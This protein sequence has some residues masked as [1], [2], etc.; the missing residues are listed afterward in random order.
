MS[1]QR[2]PFQLRGH[3]ISRIDAFSDVVFG[4]ALTLLV[5]SLEVPHTFGELMDSLHGFLPFS[6]CFFLL[7]QIWYMHYKFFRRYG[8]EDFITICL[9]SGLLFVVLLF[10]YPLKFLFTLITGHAGNGAMGAN[11]GR[12]L[13][14]IYGFGFAA[15]WLIFGLM[16]L[17]VRSHRA[18]LK[19][20]AVEL[21]DTDESI[22][23]CF[24]QMALGLLSVVVAQLL[25]APRAGLSGFVY[26]LIGAAYSYAGAHYGRMRRITEDRML[27][28]AEPAPAPA[29]AATV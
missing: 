13:M 2:I 15:V 24:A 27:A 26:M 29:A 10:V 8:L 20:N 18:E 17:N 12:T 9:N 4:F 23:I 19:L 25:S 6:I 7:M 1:D 22:Y 5:V 3:K 21:I 28:P 11:D 14:T 16:H